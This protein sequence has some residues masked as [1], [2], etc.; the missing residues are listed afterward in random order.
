[1]LRD[2]SE[3]DI[4]K[5]VVGDDRDVI[6]ANAATYVKANNKTRNL[7]MKYNVTIMPNQRV[8]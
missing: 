7:M 6:G 1:M 4:L 3:S 2:R 5:E 8:D